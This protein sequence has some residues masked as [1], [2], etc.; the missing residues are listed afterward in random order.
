MSERLR[1]TRLRVIFGSRTVVDVEEL[2]VAEAELMVVVG[3]AAAGKSSFGAALAG[4]ASYR[5]EVRVAGDQLSGSPSQRRRQGLAAALRDS[6]RISGCTVYEALELAAQG[7][8]RQAEALA[9]FPQLATRRSV[10]A[11]LLSGGEQQ[12]LRVAAAWCATAPVLI[13]DSPTVGL[14][15]D[16]AGAVATLA[17]EEAERGAAVVWL[18]QDLRAAPATPRY[19]LVRGRLRAFTPAETAGAS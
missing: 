8:D 13:L 18:E 5:G 10:P 2:A 1:V 4:A 9:R 17:R 15:R 14:A 11:Q 6:G 19:Q 7:G 3:G 12:L 16:A